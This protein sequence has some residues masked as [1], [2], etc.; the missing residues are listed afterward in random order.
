V[1]L[2]CVSAIKLLPALKLFL[3]QP[4]VYSVA[5]CCFQP[6]KVKAV[7]SSKASKASSSSKPTLDQGREPIR[8]SQR[9]SSRQLPAAAEQVGQITVM[10]LGSGFAHCV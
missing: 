3:T 4:A 7:S 10:L 6:P 8:R 9:Q 5:S 1:V 2:E